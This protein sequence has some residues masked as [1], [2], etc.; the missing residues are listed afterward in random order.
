M[1]S[2]PY[3]GFTSVYPFR[4]GQIC[5]VQGSRT[6]YCRGIRG[7]T[8]VERNESEEIL[9]ATKELLQLMVERNNLHVEDIASAIFTATEDL[10]ADFPAVAAPGSGG[11]EGPSIGVRSI[12]VPP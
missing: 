7:A 2:I 4:A 10:D 1:A 3:N 8:T 11:A 6:M 5:Y 12:C 9:A